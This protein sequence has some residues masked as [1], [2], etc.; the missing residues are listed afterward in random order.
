MTIAP[1]VETNKSQKR[2]LCMIENITERRKAEEEL[3]ETKAFLQAAMDSS[4]A[5]IAIADAPD[6]KLSELVLA[7][8]QIAGVDRL[9]KI[10]GAQA[11]AAMAYGTETVPRVDKI[12]GPGNSYVATAKR[13]VFGQVGIDMVAGPS[14]IL[15]VCDGNTDPDWVA[16]DMFAQSEHDENAQA[17]LLCP[18]A[19]YLN[20]VAASIDRLWPS[21]ERKEVIAAS[22]SGRGA[23]IKT[24]DLKEAINVSNRIAPEH[25]ELSVEDPEAL[26]P[27][28]EHAGAIFMVTY[29]RESLGS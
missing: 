8:A 2:H 12:V 13:K 24:R 15:I 7:A 16:M 10:G 1:F 28:V 22:L 14:E 29:T 11:V 6:G 26:L 21:M 17:I 3:K 18:D 9:F 4:Q 20:A 19:S 5:A 23:L 27:L 25:L